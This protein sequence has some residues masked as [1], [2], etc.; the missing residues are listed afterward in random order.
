MKAKTKIK[1]A[2]LALK[3]MCKH[4][5]TPLTLNN[6]LELINK[7]L[8]RQY[9]FRSTK[10]LA[11]LFRYMILSMKIPL[12]KHKELVTLQQAKHCNT[13]YTYTKEVN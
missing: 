3:I 9:G 11:Y 7:G 5:G 10:E 12:V 13:Y 8:T 4:K 2:E 6:W 1:R